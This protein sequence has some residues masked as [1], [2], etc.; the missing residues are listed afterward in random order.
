MGATFPA[1]GS[2]SRKV[3]GCQPKP[4]AEK[5]GMAL[6]GVPAPAARLTEAISAAPHSNDV[7]NIACSSVVAIRGPA[8]RASWRLYP[9]YG[10]HDARQAGPLMATTEE[11]AMK[12][13]GGER[14]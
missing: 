2:K 11:Q 9:G 1:I 10:R 13:R 14:Y 8:C 6:S 12:V 7:L 5:F 3:M 4:A